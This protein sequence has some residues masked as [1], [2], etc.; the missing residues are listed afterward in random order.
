[1]EVKIEEVLEGLRLISTVA[2]SEQTVNELKQILLDPT[3]SDQEIGK[4]ENFQKFGKISYF[5]TFLG[6]RE[7]FFIRF[8]F[9]LNQEVPS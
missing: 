1:M 2:D 5:P 7:S 4:K 3:L 9:L 6:I 8:D